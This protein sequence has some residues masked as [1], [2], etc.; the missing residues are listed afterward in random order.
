MGARPRDSLDAGTVQHAA[1]G[2]GG[3]IDDPAEVGGWPFLE[4]GVGY[5]DAD[6]DGMS[7]GWE[8]ANRLNPGSPTDRNGDLDGDGYTN[9][10]EFLNEIAGD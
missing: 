4:G 10:E 2:T 9:L 5:G 1:N 7:D 6:E 8:I 3:L